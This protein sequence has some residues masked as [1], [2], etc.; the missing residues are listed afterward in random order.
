MPAGLLDVTLSGTLSKNNES[1]SA[2]QVKKDREVQTQQHCFKGTQYCAKLQT[3]WHKKQ[4]W[5]KGEEGR[6]GGG[7]SIKSSR[8]AQE[9]SS[10]LCPSFP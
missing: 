3:A 2:M 5:G 1:F 7:T 8:I 10:K 9:H 6:E 4:L